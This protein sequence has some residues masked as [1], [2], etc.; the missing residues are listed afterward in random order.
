MLHA[1]L[2]MTNILFSI[3][4]GTLCIF[5]GMLDSAFTQ[6]KTPLWIYDTG[7]IHNSQSLPW[8]IPS[9]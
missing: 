9:P 8:D 5:G 3:L 1:Y 4:Q 7:M 6:A 2:Y